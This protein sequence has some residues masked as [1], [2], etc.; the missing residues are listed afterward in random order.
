MDGFD[1]KIDEF[2]ELV[3][4]PE[5]HTVATVSENDLRIQLAYDRIKSISSN[6]FYDEVGANLE[7]LVGKPITNDI[8][9]VGKEKI[10]SV[11]TY[12]QLWDTN[13]I[14][15]SAEITNAMQIIYSVYLK[16]Y[17]SETEEES[18]KEINITLDLVKGVKIKFGWE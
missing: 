7:E 3:V 13:D 5:F 1:F 14:Y 11:I 4:D 17:D 15:I 9:N 10:L 18:S 2:G 8:V 16:I 12:D 6:W